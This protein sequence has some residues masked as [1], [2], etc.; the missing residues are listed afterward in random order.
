M[1]AAALV[2]MLV[3]N[4]ANLPSPL[5]IIYRDQFHFSELTLTLI[6]AAYVIGA[7][8]ALL[9][10][11]RLS[12]Q[13][14]RRPALFLAIAAA[15]A[16]TLVFLFV[17]NTAMLF[18]AR[19]VIGF[20]AGLCASTCTAWIAELAP[21]HDR[22][23]AASAA[24][25]ANVLAL[26][27]GPLI[28]GVLAQFTPWPL[29]LPFLVYLVGLIPPLLIVW[30]IHETV[31]SRRPLRAVSFKPR[32][33]VP[34]EV[35][36]PFIA[37]AVTAF[38]V[39]ALMGFYSSLIPTVLAQDLHLPNHALGGAVIF[40]MFTCGAIAIVALYAL[41]SRAAM[42]TAL[43]LLIPG[44]LL[45]VGA[46]N[47]AS[48]PLLLAASM[49]GGISGAL[50]Y[51]GSLE[52]VNEIAPADRRAETVAVLLLV[53]YAGI[54]LPVIG[55]GILSQLVNQKIAAL[56]FALVLCVLALAAATVGWF[57]RDKDQ[58]R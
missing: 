3:F 30:T 4:A 31:Q 34:A 41:S 1:A 22:H 18:P 46:E 9:F 58:A 21:N 33:G 7:V 14:G 8:L 53:C 17:V 54:S 40:F 20:A 13:I 52:V 29:Q 11:G 2:L 15:A 51:R 10:F 47:Y 45:L 16:G 42:F 28:S 6:F 32:I 24:S 39:F 35:I 37:P 26:G 44:V 43:F 57:H 12:D 25:G 55:T 48:M 27:L 36:P 56:V 49:I 50:G 19:I 5:Y 38:V 23:L